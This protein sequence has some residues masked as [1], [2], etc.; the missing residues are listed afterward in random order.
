MSQIQ[1]EMTSSSTEY[2]RR[3]LQSMTQVVAPRPL[4]DASMVTQINKYRAVSGFANPQKRGGQMLEPSSDGR[5]AAVG[6]IAVCCGPTQR[7]I[8]ETCPCPLVSVST[9]LP[10]ACPC[11]PG[12]GSYVTAPLAEPVCCTSGPGYGDT[13]K[14]ND[15]RTDWIYGLPPCKPTMR[16]HH[17]NHHPHHH[18]VKTSC[19]EHGFLQVDGDGSDLYWDAHY[20]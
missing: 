9:N 17:Y 4:Y 18:H 16:A 10:L 7:T 8:T 6:G 1:L 14:A 2:L 3:K 13:Y 12:I 20:L 5:L 15:I 19:N 11:P